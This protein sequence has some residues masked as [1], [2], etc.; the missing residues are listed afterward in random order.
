MD[1][2]LCPHGIPIRDHACASCETPV[3]DPSAD[4][5]EDDGE[6]DHD[7]EAE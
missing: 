5:G 7:D 4:D 1:P 2:D 6:L 3:A